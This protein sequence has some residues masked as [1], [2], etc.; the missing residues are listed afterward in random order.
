MRIFLDAR[1]LISLQGRGPCAVD[2]FRKCLQGG[3]HTLV[4]SPTVIFEI[5]AP[6]S[7]PFSNTVVT[8][9]LNDLE[10]LPHVFINDVQVPATEIRSA[11]NSYATGSEYVTIDPPYADRL[12]AAIPLS[13]AAPTSCYLKHG[14]AET[15]FSMWQ[16]DRTLFRW[17]E[18][19]VNSYQL[20]MAMDRKHPTPLPPAQHFGETLRRDL[21]LYEI[22]HPRGGLDSFA[23]WVYQTPT[24]CPAVRLSYEIFHQIRRNIGDQPRASDLGD[25]AH[26]SNLPYVDLITLDRRTADYVRRA[27]PGWKDDPARKVRHDFD[28]I[29]RDL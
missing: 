23:N 25:F 4:L 13:G 5:S 12:D 17:S 6:L 21:K 15:V 16:V 26:L 2:E 11:I 27:T 28:S 7:D 29:V 24:R 8:R 20:V 19:Q 1:D 10:S 14:L 3:G 22:P 9:L 18:A